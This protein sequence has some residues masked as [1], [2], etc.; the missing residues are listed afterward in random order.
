[1]G[2]G[3]A[4]RVL[5]GVLR[6]PLV[7]LGG[8]GEATDPF[9]GFLVPGSKWTIL[10]L[11]GLVTSAAVAAAVR[12]DGA[13]IRVLTVVIAATSAGVVALSRVIGDLFAYLFVWRYALV[14]F[15]AVACIVMLLD[16]V[17]PSSRRPGTGRFAVVAL[18]AAVVVLGVATM[19]ASLGQRTDQILP[20]ERATRELTARLERRG[21]PSGEVEI[22]RFDGVLEGVAD[23]ILNRLDERG[24]PMTVRPDLT[25]KYGASRG[26]SAA[27][28]H[29]WFVTETNIGTT[30]ASA[31]PGAEV[32]ASV[33][34]LSGA[35]DA[36]LSK[37]QL[38]VVEA[39]Q[40]QGRLDLL[41]AL[42]SD[43][44]AIALTRAGVK[45]PGVD[46]DR[47]VELNAK[48]SKAGACRCAVIAVPPGTSDDVPTLIRSLALSAHS[49]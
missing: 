36:E 35:D 33:T 27:P 2:W 9:T 44:V 40:A 38:Q 1:M 29:V 20:R 47:L 8:S 25:F 11:V 42:G 6:V 19:A 22:L 45:V 5:G 46:L 39:L 18:A 15:A 16:S 17:V 12:R 10:I 30:L 28:S 37:L 21:R 34:P 48:A 41:P 14:W 7:G 24:W 31:V 43:L 13:K 4:V 32:V 23:G 49:P 3:A 26:A